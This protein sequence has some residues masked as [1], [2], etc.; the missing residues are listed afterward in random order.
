MAVSRQDRRSERAPRVTAVFGEAQANEALDHLEI[1]ELAWHVCYAEISP[2][3]EIIED[4]LVVSEGRLD[5]M[6]QAVRLG[7]TDWRDLRVAA[8]RKRDPSHRC[9]TRSPRPGS[10][11][12]GI[13]LGWGIRVVRPGM[14]YLARVRRHC[15][16]GD[17]EQARL[18]ASGVSSTT[19]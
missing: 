14:F 4:V 8:D 13:A 12:S 7:L 11:L 5:S 19:R 15:G 10:Q 17:P 3:D 6:I 1:M 18:Q 2:P 16:L 9:R